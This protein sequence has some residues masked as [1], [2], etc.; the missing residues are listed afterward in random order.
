M[1]EDRHIIMGCLREVRFQVEKKLDNDEFADPVK[2]RVVLAR[3]NAEISRRCW[4]R[5]AHHAADTGHS[6]I[7]PLG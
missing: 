2:A 5:V 7:P 6:I 4:N 3:I 1:I